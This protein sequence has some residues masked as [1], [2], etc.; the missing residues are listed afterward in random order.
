M[1]KTY[2]NNKYL[3]EGNSWISETIYTDSPIVSKESVTLKEIF[4][5]MGLSSFFVALSLILK[6]SAINV[7]GFADWYSQNI[8]PIWLNTFGRV[9]SIF[10]FSVL[11]MILLFGIGYM[12][13]YIFRV[14][15]CLIIRKKKHI[16][17]DKVN[18]R[19]R[20]AANVIRQSLRVA[21]LASL[22]FLIFTLNAGIN[23]YRDT[24]SDYLELD[25]KDYNLMD[26]KQLCMRLTEDVNQWSNL[27]ERNDQGIF[28]I[29]TDIEGKAIEA[30]NAAGKKYD[31]LAGYYPD[32]KPL[33]FSWVLSYE[34]ISGVFTPFTMEANYNK[35]IVPYNIPFTICH[36]LSHTKGFMR[37]DEANF[38]AYLACISIDDPVFRYSGSLMSWIYSTNLLYRIDVNAYQEVRN[39]LNQEVIADLKENNQ[40]WNKYKGTVS[41]ISE[42][43]NNT[44]L[45]ANGQSDGIKSYNRMV[46]LLIAYYR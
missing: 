23:Y 43:V 6:W 37:E 38:I 26:L 41:K 30:M 35:D 25:Q 7:N 33:L 3:E 12:V 46:D 10:Q 34:H 16:L 44:Y 9:S 42:K 1:N 32:P 28:I 15:I 13:L 14:V 31:I 29:D 8:Y 11:E 24:L 21:L 40:F 17:G 20:F 27:I 45:N 36:E 2:I 22:L 18:K 19:D 4:I 5:Y 39:H